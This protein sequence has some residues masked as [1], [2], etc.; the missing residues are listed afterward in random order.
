MDLTIFSIPR[1]FNGHTGLI[2]TNAIASWTRVRGADVVL[3]GDDDGVDRAAAS[4]GV[5]HEPSIERNARGTPLISDA[6]ERLRRLAASE[7]VVFVN[8]DIVFTDDL[9]DAVSAMRRS[10]FPH[11]VLVGQRRDFDVGGPIVMTE[12]WQNR[13]LADVAA[14]GTLHGKSGIDFFAFPRDLPLK[15][16]PLAVGR[17]GWDSW[18]VYA[19]RK[20]GIP[21][22][23]ATRAV[24]AIHQNH[25]PAHDPAGAEADDNR[26]SAGGFYRMGSIRDAD[27]RLVADP[28][29]R[30]RLEPRLAGRIWFAPPVRAGLAVRRALSRRLTGSRI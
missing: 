27:W 21:L 2:Q 24:C 4:L 11:W 28:D 6:F 3:M 15:L 17:V 13:L 18:L 26:R 7:V 9:A 23:D 8:G 12:G 20:A 16:P 29:G 19:T 10:R 14:R 25:P 5:R 30:L 22:V 1:P